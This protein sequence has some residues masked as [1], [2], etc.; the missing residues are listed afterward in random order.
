MRP[1]VP[2]VYIEALYGNIYGVFHLYTGECLYA[3]SFADCLDY[4][5]FLYGMRF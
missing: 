3:G 2:D 4:V 5:D 1:F